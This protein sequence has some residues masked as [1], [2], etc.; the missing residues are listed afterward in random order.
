MV[1]HQDE[2]HELTLKQLYP[3]L[4]ESELQVAGENLDQYLQLALRIW[5]RLSEKNQ[6]AISNFEP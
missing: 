6:R 1:H 4:T 5:Q 3:T 2:G